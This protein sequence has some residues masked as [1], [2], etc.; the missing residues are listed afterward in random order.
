MTSGTQANSGSPGKPAADASAPHSIASAPG[1]DQQPQPQPQPP[2]AYIWERNWVPVCP[3]SSLDPS[4]PTPV[5]LLGQPLVVWRHSV[6]GWVVIR[7]VCPHR[8]APLSEGRLE[9]GGTRLACSYHGWEFS[10]EGQCKKNPQLASDL[11]ASATACA[12]KRSC[13]TSF[14]TLELDGILFAWLDASEEGLQAARTAP[15]PELTDERAVSYFNWFMNEMPADYPFWL[16]Q[17]MDPTHAN[18][19]HEGVLFLRGAKAVSMEGQPHSPVDLLRG[20]TWQH[21]AYQASQT[22]MR[23]FREFQPPFVTRVC[24]HLASGGLTFFW[25]MSVPVRPGVARV[26]F[27]A[28]F[29]WAKSQP[30][31]TPTPAPT[32]G[33]SGTDSSPRAAV[34][35]AAAAGGPQRAAEGGSPGRRP[36]AEAGGGGGSSAQGSGALRGLTRLLGLVPHWL[37]SAQLIADQDAVMIHR[38]EVLMRRGGF[39]ARDYNLNSKADGGVAAVNVWLR[40]AGYPDSLWG[41]KPVVQS[42]PTYSSWPAQ[43][44]SLEQILSR[45]ERHVRHCTVCQRGLRQVTAMCTAL[46]AAAGLAAAAAAALAV[47]AAVNPEAVERVGGW[48]AVAGAAAVAMALAASAATGWSIREERFISGA[49]QWHRMGGFASK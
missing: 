41:G 5:V 46:T 27:K 4:S 24:Y 21:G 38:Q 42:G 36:E 9:A 25:V 3:L 18:F 28:G 40:R 26:Y 34:T 13:V 48:R 47:M 16:E 19:L 30:P 1:P 33:S 10:E 39:T 23:A 17:S 44:L 37:F 2:P 15:K 22:D 35:A 32:G 43:E 8:L 29:G 12:S 31:L 11:R 7:D 6:R 20:F 49:A 45:Q 14:P